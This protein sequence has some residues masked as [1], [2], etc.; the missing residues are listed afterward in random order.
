[1]VIRANRPARR[2][3]GRP[4]D[5]RGKRPRRRGVVLAQC[6][7]FALG[8]SAICFASP[9]AAAGSCTTTPTGGGDW[10]AYGHDAS[11]T[12][13]QPEESGFGPAAVAGPPP[14][15]GFSPR[16]TKDENRVQF[17]PLVVL[18]GAFLGHFHRLSHLLGAQNRHA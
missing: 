9:A 14:R 4:G 10:P 1:M 5:S 18:G 15:W 6:V 17:T 11:N 2:S 16:C 3:A 12:R 7:A 13:S 8:L